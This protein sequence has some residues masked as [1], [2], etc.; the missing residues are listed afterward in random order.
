MPSGSQ[1]WPIAEDDFHWITLLEEEPA[2]HPTPDNEG[3]EA[4]LRA[5]QRLQ[6]LEREQNGQV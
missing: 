1:E 6:E 2:A 4:E 3:L 5:W